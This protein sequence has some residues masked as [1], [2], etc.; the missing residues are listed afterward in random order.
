VEIE[1]VLDYLIE[2]RASCV[3]EVN[4]ANFYHS[5][6]FSWQAELLSYLVSR[7]CQLRHFRCVW[8]LST[9][10]VAPIGSTQKQI[11]MYGPEEIE[12]YLLPAG[13][14]ESIGENAEY[15]RRLRY[16]ESQP[17]WYHYVG[18]TGEIPCASASLFVKGTV[19]YLAH[20]YTHP[21]YRGRGFQGALIRERVCH[22][23]TVGCRLVFSV[24]DS[25]TQSGRNLQR[26]G[27]SLA[28]NYLMLVYD[29]AAA[30]YIS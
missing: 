17:G 16:G 14:V 9:D 22:A 24:T 18:Y 2:Q 10:S 11:V 8:Q 4:P 6:P 12:S 28:Y 30:A 27:F 23:S 29:S 5:Q 21:D 7:G 13:E 25:Y 15:T 3:I 19:G 20:A 1:N 26:E